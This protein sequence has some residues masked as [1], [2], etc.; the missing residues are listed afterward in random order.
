MLDELKEV[1]WGEIRKT[2]KA[3]SSFPILQRISSTDTRQE[4]EVGVDSV[5]R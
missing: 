1:H 5:A 2:A 3:V 4:Y